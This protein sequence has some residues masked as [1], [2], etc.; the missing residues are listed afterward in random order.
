MT[1]V[2]SSIAA[3][4]KKSRD[5]LIAC[6]EGPDGDCLGSGLALRLALAKLGVPAQVGSTDG[7]P[8][9]F[10]ALPGADRVLTKPTAAR[11]D[12]AVAVECS[13]P[14]RAGVFAEALT[15]AKTLINIDHHVSNTGYGHLVYQDP[16]AAAAGELMIKVIQALGVPIDR[17]IAECLLTAVI[18]D[19]GAFHYPNTT[20]RPLRLVA[21]LVEAGAA[22]SPIVERVYETKTAAQLR[23]WGAALANIRLSADGRIVWTTVTPEMTAST[24]ARPEDTTGIVTL[25]RQIRGVQIALLFE[26][27]PRGVRVSIRSRKDGARSNVIAEAFGGGGHPNAAGFIG[28][29][30][31]DQVV[32]ATLVEAEKEL[33]QAVPPSASSRP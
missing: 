20:E 23:L 5:V 3:A 31:L 22:V 4:L 9:A 29:G 18:T 13:T 17:D 16:S 1:D 26:V 27:I 15:D 30:M 24:G 11:P 8:D 19:T 32:A 10:L 14:D 7:V 6:H 12:V 28:T 21:D 33:R 2:L 25:L